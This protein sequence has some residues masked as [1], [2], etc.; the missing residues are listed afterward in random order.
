MTAPLSRWLLAPAALAASTSGYAVTYL[1]AEQ[2]QQAIFPG[3]TFTAVPVTLTPEQRRIVDKKSGLHLRTPVIDAWRTD[4]G[5]WFFVDRVLGKHEFI[6][7]A[8]GIDAKGAVVGVEI[9]D[10]RETYGDEIRNPKW[11]AQFVGK[12]DRDPLKLDGDIKNISGATLSSRH[13]TSGV[14]RLLAVHALV[15][16][17]P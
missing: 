5:G 8:C 10:Y 6:T 17:K 3:A 7:Y 13:I 4:R 12:T 9:L 15:L 16:A 1:T 14:K 2:A 11:R